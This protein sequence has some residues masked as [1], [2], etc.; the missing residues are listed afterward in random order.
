MDDKKIWKKTGFG[1]LF[2][3]A[4]FM[5]MY[6]L[7]AFHSKI[8]MMLLAAILLL[9]SAFL[10]FYEI[11]ADKT[12]HSKPKEEKTEITKD[13]ISGG[14]DAEF[15]LKISKYM[16]EME[17]SQKE[18]VEILKNQN[19]LIQNQLDNLEQ[20]IFTLS[21]KQVNQTKSVIKFNKENA[22]QLAISERETLEYVMLELKQAIKDNA[23]TVRVAESV[24]EKPVQE[25]LFDEELMIAPVAELEEVGD[26]ELFE[27]SDLPG[28]DEYIIPE[29]PAE[30]P[31][32]EELPV[33]EEEPVAEEIPVFEE[34]PVA[35][36]LPVF[37]EETVVDNEPAPAVDPLAGLSGDPNA[38]M[39]AED[40]AKLFAMN[41]T[42]EPVAEE[43][44]VEPVT[45]E[46]EFAD[47]LD[48]S[49]LFEDIAEG[50]M[51]EEAATSEAVAEEK[52]EEPAPAAEPMAALSG[53]PN[54]M[55][56]P[57][58]IAKLLASMGQ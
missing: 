13:I 19:T 28:D 11:F 9:V 43:P 3:A 29:K 58:D 26:E 57:E 15:R 37:E 45:E 21:E 30:E 56:T 27:V 40:I 53:D 51:A 5:A 6:I 22:R 32:A 46:P 35:E 50:A 54:A 39:S 33:F 12:E 25:E 34:E 8:L 44:M 2:V 47:D 20:A 48:L 49:A 36:E 14:N 24:S 38:M 41:A 17:G 1:I 10:F 52:A 18:L 16:K 55:M 23:G 7:M 31:V 42:E 4:C